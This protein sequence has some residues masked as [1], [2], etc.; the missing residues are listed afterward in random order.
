MS[1]NHATNGTRTRPTAGTVLALVAALVLPATVAGLP[2]DDAPALDACG[3]TGVSTSYGCEAWVDRKELIGDYPV[4]HVLGNDIRTVANGRSAITVWEDQ[5]GD[6]KRVDT[7]T[8]LIVLT[9]TD[10]E[11]GRTGWTA[12]HLGPLAPSSDEGS[13]S[14]D[15]VVLSPDGG[16]VYMANSYRTPDDAGVTVAAFDTG[17]GSLLWETRP[18]GASGWSLWPPDLVVAGDG[19]AVFVASQADESDLFLARL[20]ASTGTVSW[21]R[22]SDPAVLSDGPADV[23]IHP[24]G[25]T[26][27]LGGEDLRR[28][29][30]GVA[31]LAAYD[32][33]DGTEIWTRS[34]PVPALDSS[35]GVQEVGVAPDGRHIYAAIRSA[36]LNL[37][38]VGLDGRDGDLRWTSDPF[39]GE[40]ARY[41]GFH[42]GPDD[43]QVYV[44]GDRFS[45]GNGV[46]DGGVAF[47]AAFDAADGSRSWLTEHQPVLPDQILFRSIDS[48]LRDADLGPDGS[49]LYGAGHVD[50]TG[51][52]DDALT[53]AYNTSTGTIVQANRYAGRGGHVDGNHV[54]GTDEE[55]ESIAITPKG[56]SVVAAGL[57]DDPFG[58][59]SVTTLAYDADLLG[60]AI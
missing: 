18:T 3:A 40:L 36:D 42:V 5:S 43:E 33:S 13:I 24:D 52:E 10:L 39:G 46:L 15:D 41:D 28:G 12:T 30:D 32:A 47:A 56:S 23:A 59:R 27:Y 29:Q 37:A 55:A 8:D 16:T 19:S 54:E 2:V 58:K 22:T 57:F 51:T 60:P 21:T 44:V 34:V 1:R 17:S 4:R 11:T 31:G 20:G 26:L 38:V 35:H 14:L 50:Q 25:R 6:R 53:L 48:A 9:Q 45:E 49:R 7:T